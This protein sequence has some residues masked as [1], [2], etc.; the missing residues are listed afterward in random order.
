MNEGIWENELVDAV[1][2]KAARVR[3]LPGKPDRGRRQLNC[4]ET[5]VGEGLPIGERAA[6]KRR[7]RAR[8]R[9]GIQGGGK[10][11]KKKK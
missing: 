6:A 4:L 7:A 11:T 1:A 3:T 8:G 9:R 5:L 10:K 2:R